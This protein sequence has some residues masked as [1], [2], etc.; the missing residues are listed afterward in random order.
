MEVV[1]AKFWSSLVHML[2]DYEVEFRGAKP[3]HPAVTM[4]GSDGI[5][6]IE[7]S[8]GVRTEEIVPTVSLKTSVLVLR[9][10]KFCTFI[11]MYMVRKR[12]FIAE[13]RF[14]RFYIS[15]GSQGPSVYTCMPT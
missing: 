3:D 11:C 12:C 15:H 13:F 8:S 9:L 1:V 5:H 6:T 4:L 14:L 10:V 2:V 7:I